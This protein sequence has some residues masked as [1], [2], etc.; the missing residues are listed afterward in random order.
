MTDLPHFGQSENLLSFGT[1]VLGDDGALRLG[2]VDF[3]FTIC[4]AFIMVEKAFFVGC[5]ID[6][7]LF[8]I[9]ISESLSHSRS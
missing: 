6:I 1:L 4:F 8:T 5:E 7:G 3:D 9:D 2:D